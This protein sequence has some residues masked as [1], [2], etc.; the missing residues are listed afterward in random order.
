MTKV[1]LLKAGVAKRACGAKAS[2]ALRT[3]SSA[4]RLVFM[5][6]L[7]RMNIYIYIMTAMRLG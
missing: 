3:E 1:E 6:D 4:R 2:A 7:G 5:I